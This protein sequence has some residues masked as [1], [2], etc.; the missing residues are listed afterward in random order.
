MLGEEDNERSVEDLM[1]YWHSSEQFEDMMTTKSDEA[2]KPCDFNS[3]SLCMFA[4]YLEDDGQSSK[5]ITNRTEALEV[6]YDGECLLEEEGVDLLQQKEFIYEILFG[7]KQSDEVDMDQK[8]N[9]NAILV[10]QEGKQMNLILNEIDERTLQYDSV[11][12]KITQE[13]CQEKNESEDGSCDE[14]L[15]RFHKEIEFLERLLKELEEEMKL[16]EPKG[17]KDM[18]TMHDKDELSLT[19]IELS[20]CL[21]PSVNEVTADVEDNINKYDDEIR[22]IEQM[23]FEGE[24]KYQEQQG[25]YVPRDMKGKKVLIQHDEDGRNQQ[26]ERD[27]QLYESE[28]EEGIRLQKYSNWQQ[29]EEQE[30]SLA[31]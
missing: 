1:D 22:E 26:F 10:L 30:T 29:N 14:L 4:R 25:S 19:F 8:S 21:D 31:E 12:N 15:E 18:V 23:L 3:H 24:M 6:K 28:F 13:D 17:E 2:M 5:T 11:E 7:V 16:P 27:N 20:K 9:E